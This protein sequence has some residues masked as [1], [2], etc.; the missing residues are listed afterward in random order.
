MADNNIN[1]MNNGGPYPPQNQHQFN[2]VPQQNYPQQQPYPPQ[3]PKKKK[4]KTVWIVLGAIL[5]FIILISVFSSGGKDENTTT[6][7][8]SQSGISASEN[9]N[10]NS[11]GKVGDY[12]CVV[13]SAELCKDWE[14]K[15]AI[16]ITYSFTNNSDE[17]QSFDV[18]F[19][20][21]VFQNGIELETVVSV[22]G[23]EDIDWLDTVEI[24][25]GVT[26]EVVKAYK[27]NDKTTPLEVEISE[28]LGFSDDV[29]KTTIE[30]KK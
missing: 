1:N 6:E 22:K 24:K 16:K 5:A 12:V 11:D 23:E 25:P 4:K 7:N 28:F 26:K 14:G 19:E 29:Y 27:L 30:L 13:K 20:D 2:T 10:V 21:K 17:A 15:D 18:A 9:N 3:P 8:Q